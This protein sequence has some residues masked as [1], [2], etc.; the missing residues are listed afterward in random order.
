[1]DGVRRARARVGADAAE[2]GLPP[3]EWRR[4][5]RS[6]TPEPW[7][8]DDAR[9]ALG[10]A[11][12]SWPRRSCP[13]RW[14]ASWSERWPR[15]RRGI[16]CCGWGAGGGG[17]RAAAVGSAAVAGRAAGRWDCIRWWRCTG[18][19]PGRGSRASG[20]PLRILVAIAAPQ[21][22]GQV[23]L[24]YEHE[25]R[26]V[27]KAVS[28]ARSRTRRCGSCRSRPWRRSGPSWRP[29][30]S[31]C[32]I[33][34]GTDRPACCTWRMPT[35]P[36]RRGRRRV[37]GPGRSRRA[38]AAGGGVGRVLHGR[39]RRGDTPSFAARLCR[40]WGLGGDRHRD[41]DHRCLC[42]P[43]ARPLLRPAG[44]GRHR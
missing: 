33:C 41:L 17:V 4:V 35:A 10:Q 37:R 21:T 11:G 25:L 44:G 24:N 22:G 6:L 13:S 28:S 42:H 29:P 20:G 32:C 31:T 40:A 1:M 43:R 38:D 30:T 26:M 9:S 5:G 12:L 3:D 15:R 8:A 23:L 36:A 7:T 34:P 39:G 19:S 2:L 16:S 14:P 18:T 27:L